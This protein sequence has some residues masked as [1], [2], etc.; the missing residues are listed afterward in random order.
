W[1]PAELLG[2][3][4]FPTYRRLGVDV[5]EVTI[6]WNEVAPTRPQGDATDPGNS[7]YMWPSQV[8]LAVAEARRSGMRVATTVEFAPGWAN[9]G[10]DRNWAPLSP[11]DFSDFV[12]AAAR[13]YSSVKYWLVWGEPGR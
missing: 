4:A 5:Y 10:R 3:S 11:R 13:H 1:G 12:T 7:A 2:R 8:D 9:G 6:Q